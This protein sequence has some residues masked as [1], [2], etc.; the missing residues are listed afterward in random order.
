M[1]AFGTC[2]N[3][4]EL[5]RDKMKSGMN[6]RDC[7]PCRHVIAWLG[8]EAWRLG[9]FAP[10]VLKSGRYKIGLFSKPRPCERYQEMELP[11]DSVFFL[12]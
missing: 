2:V 8:L 3:D 5:S 9:G 7:E 12:M 6:R 11:N 10:S 1:C 4:S